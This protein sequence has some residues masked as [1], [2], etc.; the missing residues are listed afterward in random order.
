MSTRWYVYIV[1]CR[2]GSLY[3]GICTDLDRRVDEHN[4]S[5]RGAKYTRSR[6]PV[7]LVYSES[8]L[9]RSEASKREHV[10]KKLKRVDKLKL[11]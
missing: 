6:R 8:V 7:R 4:G 11:I 5:K 9:N 10:I 3:T 2:D 1:R